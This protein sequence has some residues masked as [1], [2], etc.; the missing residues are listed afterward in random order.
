MQAL[1]P[2]DK[3][4]GVLWK[5]GFGEEPEGKMGHEGDA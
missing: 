3:A 1:I 2:E 5:G 4:E